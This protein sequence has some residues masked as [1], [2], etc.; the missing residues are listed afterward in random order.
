MHGV[1]HAVQGRVE[2]LL[3]SFRIEAA[4]ELRRV[5]DVGKQDRHLFAFAFQGTARGKDLFREVWWC[6]GKRRWFRLPHWRG[7]CGV[8]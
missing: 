4:D 6:I 7:R 3:G 8:S 5:F 1:H 2:Q